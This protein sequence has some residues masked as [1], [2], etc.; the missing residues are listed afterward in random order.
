M[1]FFDLAARWLFIVC[2][3][4]LLISSNIRWAVNEVRLYEYGFD[5]YEVS[6]TTGLEP[7]ELR[8]AAEGLIGYFNSDDEPV[9]IMVVKDEEEFD[10]FNEREVAH[11]RDVKGL[12]QLD[13]RLQLG[14]L[15]YALGFVAF[16]LGWR[17]RRYRRSLARGAL[18]GGAL[19]IAVM[20]ALG[21]G[22]LFGF[23]QLFLQFH[24][25]GFSNELWV[26][27]P[28]RDYLIM[29]FPQGFFYYAALFVAV[30]TAAGGLILGGI[31]VFFLLARG[32]AAEL[33]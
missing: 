6:Q 14:T 12:I 22:T 29:M 16:G 18:G 27:D 10:L 9:H 20:L 26:L 21:I 13:Y 31:G 3:P 24:L 30:A 8:R 1:R 11:L 17:K 32:K 4:V 7:G 19:T 33:G 23:E 2:I 5:K 15:V 28:A 25:L